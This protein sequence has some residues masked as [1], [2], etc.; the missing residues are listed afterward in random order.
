MDRKTLE[1]IVEAIAHYSGYQQPDSA[2][3]AARNPI[4]LRPMKAE[5]PRDDQGYRVFRSMLDGMQAAMF[6]LEI[7]LTA[8]LSPDSTLVDLATAYGRQM[9]E[10]QA[11]ARFLRQA[12][13]D[14]NIS[15]RTPIRRFLNE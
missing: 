4:G 3:Y 15:A 1:G 13:N 7:K 8:R 10:A 11:W 9:T 14:Q 6:D 2:L 5:Q 12:L